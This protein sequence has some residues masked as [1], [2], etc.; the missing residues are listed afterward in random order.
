M[1]S[2]SMENT[3]TPVQ[4]TPARGTALQTAMRWLGRIVVALFALGIVIFVLLPFYWMLKSSF[5][6][7]SEIIAVPPVWIPRDFTLEGY[8]RALTMIPFVRYLT[9]SL[10]IATATTVVSALLA[11]SAAYVLARYAFPGATVILAIFLFTQL[12]PAITRIFPVYFLIKNLDLINTYPGAIIAYVS[13]SLPYAV[14]MLSGYFRNSYPVE[15]EDAAL[16]DGCTL[17]SVF[18]RIVLPISLPGIV[19]IATFTFLGA[20]NDFLWASLLLYQG[21][22]KTLQVGLRDFI[23]ELGSVQR[24]NA[25]MA[26]CVMATIPALILFSIG[27]K[28]MVQGISAGAVKG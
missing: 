12:I 4:V 17:F 22:M 13:F 1:I 28:N 10:V 18:W 16:I 15:L 14:L 7:N 24:A 19:A 5:Q 6:T 23:A 11:S 26:A 20:W 21:Q 25:F 9:N 3:Q 8:Q 2:E 27:Q